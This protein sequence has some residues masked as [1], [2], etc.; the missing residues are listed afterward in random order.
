MG[1]AELM[2][3][4]ELGQSNEMVERELTRLQR[5]KLIRET[6]RRI[7]KQTAPDNGIRCE[8]CGKSARGY[9]QPE[10]QPKRAACATHLALRMFTRG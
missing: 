1:G 4:S 5:R 9:I 3:S 7:L 8:D 6:E 2:G 10:G